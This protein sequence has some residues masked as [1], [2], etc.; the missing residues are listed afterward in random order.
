M[1]EHISESEYLEEILRGT[2]R[3]TRLLN[4]CLPNAIFVVASESI[5]KHIKNIAIQIGRTD[6]EIL[7]Y[8]TVLSNSIFG[9]NN[10]SEIVCD[11]FLKMTVDEWNQ[12]YRLKAYYNYLTKNKY[13]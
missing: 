6:I 12:I 5:A 11:H 10:V 7:S 4:N 9:K 13:F 2:G 1:K 8:N 3:T